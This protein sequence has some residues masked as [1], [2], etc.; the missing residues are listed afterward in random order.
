MIHESN[1]TELICD[2]VESSMEEIGWERL[3]RLS[4]WLMTAGCFLATYG[5]IWSSGDR[6]RHQVRAAVLETLETT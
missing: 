1:L 5:P 3:W 6:A 4:D 2:R